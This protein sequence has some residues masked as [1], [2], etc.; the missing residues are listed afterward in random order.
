MVVVVKPQVVVVKPQAQ[1]AAEIQGKSAQGVG[2]VTTQAQVLVQVL[3]TSTQAMVQQQVREES[4][5]GQ[6]AVVMGK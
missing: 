2:E 3:V 6:V 4:S 1:V 5:P